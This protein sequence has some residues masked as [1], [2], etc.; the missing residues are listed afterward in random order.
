MTKSLPLICLFICLFLPTSQAQEERLFLIGNMLEKAGKQRMLTQKIAKA[1]TAIYLGSNTYQSQTELNEAI[2]AF[3]Q[4]LKLLKSTKVTPRFKQLVYKTE[5]LWSPY[6]NLITDRPTKDNI[7]QLL[8]DNNKILLSSNLIVEEL[9]VYSQ[10]FAT[11]QQS[12]Q[13]SS[14]VIQLENIAG[15][16]R[17]LSQRVLF[18]YLAHQAILEDNYNI[19]TELNKTLKEYEQALVTLMGAPENTP[20]IDYRLSLLSKEWERITALCQVKITDLSKVQEIL[21]LGDQMLAS[22]DTITKLYE[23]LIDHKVASLLFSNAVDIAS[24]QSILTQKIIRVYINAGM[25]PENEAHAKEVNQYVNTFEEHI[26]QLKLFAPTDEITTA[27]ENVDRLWTPY[28]NQALLASTQEGAQHLLDLNSELLQACENVVL[29]LELYAK[30]YKKSVTRFNSSIINWMHQ[31]KRQEMLAERILMYSKAIVWKISPDKNAKKIEQIGYEYIDNLHRLNTIS[32]S[33]AITDQTTFLIQQWDIIKTKIADIDKNQNELN[34]WTTT[35]PRAINQLTHL[36]K[37]KINGMVTEEAMNKAD[38]QCLLSQQITRTYIAISMDLDVKQHQQ[39]LEKHKLHFQQNLQELKAFAE[40]PSIQQALGKINQLW[41]NYQGSLSYKINKEEVAKLLEQ[42]QELL[43]ACVK[44]A[45]DINRT[46]SQQGVHRIHKAAH[47]RTLTEQLLLHALIHR[48]G[49]PKQADHIHE[50]LASFKTNLQALNSVAENSTQVKASIQ[51]IEIY[52]NR[53]SNY[54][55]N[56]SST[57]LY[58]IILLHNAMLVETEKLTKAYE[59]N[60]LF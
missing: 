56:L 45:Q 59:D 39:Q 50:L 36:Y 5:S 6:K 53:F 15:K 38:Y 10:R 8:K 33:V 60:T 14:S 46:S 49:I 29:M 1:Y 35:L 58:S 37:Q 18:Y 57:D 26:D 22:M 28:R 16:Q 52:I 11:D 40:S 30:I 54:A 44:V 3:E 4:N 32:N 43:N 21:Q 19:K 27:L 17:M 2:I 41:N 55:E 24:Q 34:A 31:I 13:A 47:L 42:N 23:Q 20:E 25:E 51:Q 12:Q 7:I 9:M 48:W